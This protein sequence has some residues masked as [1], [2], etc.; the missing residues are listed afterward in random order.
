MSL[1]Q[2]ELEQDFIT[3]IEKRNDDRVKQL[4][5]ASAFGVNSFLR[6]RHKIWDSSCFSIL[7]KLSLVLFE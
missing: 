3:S 2:I 7:C 1:N 6:S 5:T 4:L